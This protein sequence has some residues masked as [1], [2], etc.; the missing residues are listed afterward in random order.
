MNDATT[1]RLETIDAV[2]NKN[3]AGAKNAARA[4]RETMESLQVKRDYLVGERAMLLENAKLSDENNNKNLKYLKAAYSFG[5][6]YLGIKSTELDTFTKIKG[7]LTDTLGLSGKM[8]GVASLLVTY[9]LAAFKL[10]NDLD[11]VG[12]AFRKTMGVVRSD[13]KDIRDS[14]DK[15]AIKMMNL[16]VTA[17][18]LNNSV[19]ALGL[20]MGGIHNVTDEIRD[21]VA[22]MKD[23]LGV[24]EKTSAGFLRNMAGVANKTLGSQVNMT[25]MAQSLSAAAG[26]NLSEVMNDIS[27]ASDHTLA[28]MSR[29]PNQMLRATI[30]ARRLG[31]TINE[32]AAANR[33]VLDFTS[34][35]QD[36]M[37]ASVLLGHSINLQKLR[38][39]SFEGDIEGGM[40]ERIR[41]AE[42]E[43]FLNIKNVFQKEAMAK[44]LGTSVESLTKQL[45][46]NKEIERMR[47]STNEKERDAVRLYEKKL[48]MSESEQDI[49]AKRVRDS[50]MNEGNQERITNIANSYHKIMANLAKVVL[51]AIDWVLQAIDFTLNHIWWLGGGI[52]LLWSKIGSLLTVLGEKIF[53]IGVSRN[54]AWLE[55]VGDMMNRLGG[56]MGR[57]RGIIGGIFTAGGRLGGLFMRITAPFRSLG[58]IMKALLAPLWV[59]WA[60]V[61][62]IIT[63]IVFAYKI[64]KEIKNILNDEKLMST[65]DFWEFNKKLAVR[66]IGGIGRALWGA[67]NFFFMGVPGMILWGIKSIGG[68][69]SDAIQEP[70]RDTWSW[71]KSTFLGESPSVLGLMIVDGLKSVGHM[72]FDA[73]T[74]PFR[75]GWA[76]IKKHVPGVEWAVNKVAGGGENVQKPLETRMAASYIPAATITP[77]GTTLANTNSGGGSPS[78]TVT[79]DMTTLAD[80]VKSNN[81]VLEAIN[82]L[83][84]DLNAGKIAVYM[85]SSKVSSV[86]A[87]DSIYRGR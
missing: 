6:Q 43:D 56:G 11:K 54:W 29:M 25:Y 14:V 84:K 82:G 44:A 81:A 67:L 66:A 77:Q 36:E 75:A 40:K 5:T 86:M 85:D 52:L 72:M 49:E 1:K 15:A 27:T 22:L 74:S 28:F 31:T 33:K 78:S 23:Q 45:V 60:V 53:F 30:E 63:P 18:T 20:E 32:V 51:P 7:Q 62:R 70:F 13:V 17:E 38:Q 12:T 83:W 46:A 57:L 9:F 64:Y 59:I 3:L 68:M 55:K 48:A 2:G 69:L 73:L 10:F 19:A 8:A 21:N 71:L 26:T 58:I 42:K 37:E 80:V 35:I 76:W 79:S 87:Q 34:S 4:H 24:S 41:I 16:G 61:K 50:L 65:Q 39:L 47:N